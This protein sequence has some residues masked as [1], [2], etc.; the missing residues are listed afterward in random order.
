MSGLLIA[1]ECN[2]RVEKA[3]RNM[4]NKTDQYGCPGWFHHE[5]AAV[6]T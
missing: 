3:T 4:E 6:T 1:F 5:T 2:E